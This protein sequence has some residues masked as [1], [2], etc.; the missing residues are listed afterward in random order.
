MELR[1]DAAESDAPRL[2]LGRVGLVLRA[3]EDVDLPAPANVH[4]AGVFQ[5]PLPL[6]FQQ[7]TGN[8]ARPEVDIVLR[9]LGDFL[10]DDDVADLEAATRF[11]HTED[12][13]HHLY[14]VGAQIDH[15]VA[16]SSGCRSRISLLVQSQPHRLFNSERHQTTAYRSA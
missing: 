1:L 13:A 9:V 8:S 4:E 2:E 6:C 3:G 15:A 12:L 10:V 5:H 16:D 14:L 7:S 11:Q